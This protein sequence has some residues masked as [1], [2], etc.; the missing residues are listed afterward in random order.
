MTIGPGTHAP[1]HMV[2]VTPYIDCYLLDGSTTLFASLFN[3]LPRRQPIPDPFCVT[4]LYTLFPTSGMTN[5]K[6]ICTFCLTHYHSM[7]FVDASTFSFL[8]PMCRLGVLYKKIEKEKA[9]K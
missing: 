9:A 4:L 8:L 7:Y 1:I 2:Q 6:Q 3:M 5:S